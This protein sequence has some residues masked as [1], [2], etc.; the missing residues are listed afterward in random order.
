MKEELQ[1]SYTAVSFPRMRQLV[2]D[3]G[4]MGKR[5]HMMHGFIEVDVTLP[6]QLIAQ[7]AEQTGR[8]L[9]FSAFILACIGEA[10]AQD[11]R[12]QAMRDWRNRLI[13]FDHVDVLM[14]FEIPVDKRTF[15]LVHTIRGVNQRAVN[16][17]HDEIRA[18]QAKPAQSEGL[19]SPLLRWFYW[20]PT[21]LRRICYR[22][23]EKN[24]HWRKKYSGTVGLTSVGMFGKGGGWGMGMPTH[25]LAITLGG[26]AE[27]PA[28][29]NG[30][31][32]PREYLHVTLSF[33]HDVIDGAPAARFTK[34]FRELVENG[35]G[36]SK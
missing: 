25:A 5:K 3:A 35:F 21:F 32:E 26:I 22:F 36:L 12:V 20:L 27:K 24:P 7:Q 34:T 13:Y 33:D 29:R 16:D 2:L 31:V 18:I 4:W 1:E 6:R 14:A 9:S 8:K 17:I 23:V 19:Q 15:P 28:W 10:V 30:R 11:N